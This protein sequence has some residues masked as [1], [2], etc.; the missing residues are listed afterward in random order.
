[1]DGR[2]FSVNVPRR[3]NYEEPN[4]AHRVNTPPIS[5]DARKLCEVRSRSRRQA[6]AQPLAERV[7]E[8]NAPSPEITPTTN[9]STFGSPGNAAAL[10]G[11]PNNLAAGTAAWGVNS[12]TQKNA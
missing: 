1:M 6:I 8:E 10:P 12:I 4:D 5:P 7:S 3:L 2:L 11:S 9:S